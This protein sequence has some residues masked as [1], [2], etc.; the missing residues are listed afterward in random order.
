VRVIRERVE[1]A[2]VE[3]SDTVDW[4]DVV[5]DMLKAA[6]VILKDTSPKDIT[7]AA[8][9]L[10]DTDPSFIA[11]AKDELAKRKAAPAPKIDLE[12]LGIHVDHE[13]IAKR[14]AATKAK[15]AE[16]LSAA[17]AGRTKKTAGV[18]KTTKSKPKATAADVLASVG[19]AKPE[20][21]ITH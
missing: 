5:R 18:G 16:T 1:S 14:Q 9:K 12:A 6:G 7:E 15:R 17:Q 2:N 21:H 8:K 11:K 13:A 3:D 10:I 20:H 19:A 4:D